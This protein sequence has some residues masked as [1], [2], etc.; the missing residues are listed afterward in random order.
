MVVTSRT[1]VL[2]VDDLPP[3]VLP[4]AAPSAA[5]F[6]VGLTMAQVEERAIR[7]T[8]AHTGGNRS[9]AARVLD[10][11]LRTL[12]RKIQRYGIERVRKPKS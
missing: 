9:E 2:D 3:E 10:I 12:H 4:P 11:G 7:E 5:S 1:R 8:L 6:P